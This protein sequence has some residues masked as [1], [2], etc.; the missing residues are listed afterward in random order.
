M[1]ESYFAWCCIGAESVPV[2]LM[3]CRGSSRIALQ[4]ERDDLNSIGGPFNNRRPPREKPKAKVFQNG[5][6]FVKMRFEEGLT[7]N[8]LK[9]E[10]RNRPATDLDPK[11]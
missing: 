7:L 6:V 8:V 5:M 11:P 9:A 1:Q 4:K 2:R 3:R 10:W